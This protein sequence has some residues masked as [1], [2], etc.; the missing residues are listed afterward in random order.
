MTTN[1]YLRDPI[2]CDAWLTRAVISS[3]AIEG[4]NA[5]ACRALGVKGQIKRAT[6]E[7]EASTSSR[8]RR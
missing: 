2:E 5:A 4:A 6:V 7:N 8:S 3:S 1:P